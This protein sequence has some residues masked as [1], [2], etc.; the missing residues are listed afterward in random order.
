MC[1]APDDA[2]IFEDE[3][4]VR[5]ADR[6]DP[7]PDD[8]DGRTIGVGVEAEAQLRVR[9]VV[10]GREGVIEDVQ[11]GRPVQGSCNGQARCAASG[12]STPETV[13]AIV[14]ENKYA[15]WGTIAMRER[16][17]ERGRSLRSWPL[18][19]RR[20]PVGSIMRGSR[21][22]RVVLPEA[23]A[24]MMAVVV[25]GRSLRFRSSRTASSAPG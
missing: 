1:S 18:T 13:E 8:E 21:F 19:A 15:F 9:C 14:P 5:V 6:G 22:T 25:P 24:P 10:E 17:S 4:L 3:D 23:V 7:L 12:F 2:P 20:P 16:S 11:L